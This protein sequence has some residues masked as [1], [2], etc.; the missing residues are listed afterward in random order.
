MSDQQQPEQVIGP[1][2]VG[3]IPAPIDY[4]YEDSAGVGIPIHGYSAKFEVWERDTPGCLIY[5]AIPDDL[6][7]GVVK[8]VWAGGEFPTPGHYQARFW[9]GNLTQRF[10]SILIKFDVAADPPGCTVPQI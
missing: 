8:Y 4:Q 7:A 10:A 1:F 6:D 9:I 2:V 3:E 5:D